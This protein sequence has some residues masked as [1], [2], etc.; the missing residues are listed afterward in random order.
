[1]DYFLMTAPCGLDCFNCHF[2]LA[3]EDQEAREKV[4]ALSKQLSIPVEIMLCRGC[5]NHRG[6]IPLQQHIFGKSHRCAAYECS[7][8]KHGVDFCGECEEFPCDY[9]HPYADKA[10]ILPHNT[11]V[12]NLCLINRLGLDKW[13]ETKAA[14]VRETYFTKPWTLKK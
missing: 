5:R 1:M 12:F 4:E 13:A 14:K 9:L 6:K 8:K 10:D 2:F 7:Q 3:N 11:K